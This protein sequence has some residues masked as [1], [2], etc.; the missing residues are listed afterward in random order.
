MRFWKYS[1][2]RFKFID[3]SYNANPLSVYSAINNFNLIKKDSGQKNI[4]LGDML[5]LGKHSKKLQVLDLSYCNNIQLHTIGHVLS[6]LPLLTDLNLR[7]YKNITTSGIEHSSLRVLNLSW[8]KNIE[9]A[10]VIQ[11]AKTN[12]SR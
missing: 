1:Y 5:E 6:S 2:K 9:D 11:I 10:A 8:C 4:I 3:E 12:G 7:G